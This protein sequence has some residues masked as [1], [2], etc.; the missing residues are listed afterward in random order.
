MFWKF[1]RW[2]GTLIVILVALGALGSTTPDRPAGTES[3]AKNF[4][5]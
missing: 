3:Q 4:N 1:I 5:L 2:G